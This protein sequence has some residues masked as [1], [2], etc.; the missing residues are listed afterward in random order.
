VDRRS[1][2][3]TAPAK[4]VPSAGV[5]RHPATT[6]SEHG[7][8]M[9]SM[10]S[11]VTDEK[12]DQFRQEGYFLLPSVL[13]ESDV[14]LLRSG[15]EYSI[16]KADAEMDALG[17]DT[18]DINTRGRRYFSNKVAREKRDLRGF[19]FGEL[20]ADICRAVIGDT[21]YLFNEQYVIKC[22]D[23]ATAFAWHQDSGYIHERHRPY[24]TC[25][26]ALD[27]VDE[28]NGAIYLLPYSQSGIRTYVHH[29]RDPN[30]NDMVGYFGATLGV[31]VEVTAGS[32]VCFSSVVFHRSGPNLT[33]R[34]RRVYVAQYSPEVILDESGQRPWDGSEPFLVGGRIVGNLV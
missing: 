2:G 9:S 17:T 24:L 10:T 30:L 32:I 12:R 27:D 31:P 4:A 5:A 21:V 29:V 23:R 1:P 15:A 8:V 28:S 19:L 20:M 11:V 13:A 26:I 14:E 25:W 22:A 7:G 3:G 16:A 6:G 34:M 18:L 33:D